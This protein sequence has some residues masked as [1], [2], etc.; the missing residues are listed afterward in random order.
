[1][2]SN[3]CFGWYF[4][5]VCISPGKED[6]YVVL[7]RSIKLSCIFRN[8]NKDRWLPFSVSSF[9]FYEG[10]HCWCK[11]WQLHWLASEIFYK[12]TVKHW[13]NVSSSISVWQPEIR[14]EDQ[15]QP[16]LSNPGWTQVRLGLWWLSGQLLG[17]LMNCYTEIIH[18][19]GDGTAVPSLRYKLEML[20]TSIH[21]NY[22]ET[23]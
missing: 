15:G 7:K 13:R 11:F 14:E 21:H 19:A 20:Y 5:C 23:T 12:I 8:I 6:F 1:M 2:P 22:L 18:G 9:G 4:V 10:L 3:I 17:L 16:L